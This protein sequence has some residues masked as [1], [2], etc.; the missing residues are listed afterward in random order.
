M[1]VVVEMGGDDAHA[2]TVGANPR[3]G[4]NV[5]EATLIVAIE[6]VPRRGK[7]FGRTVDRQRPSGTSRCGGQVI[8][9][10]VGDVEV[11]IPISL[12]VE[13]CATHAPFVA[14]GH[15]PGP[16]ERT[17]ATVAIEGV[18]AVVEDVQVEIGVPRRCHR[19][20]PP[21][22]TRHR[23]HRMSTSHPRTDRDRHFGRDD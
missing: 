4:G 15:R 11:Q 23:Q 8:A 20:L 13:E 9:Q 22:R 19:P 10:V 7:L 6:L 21:C 16:L 17:V 1:L 3:S 5:D 2:T 18:G 14:R 12:G